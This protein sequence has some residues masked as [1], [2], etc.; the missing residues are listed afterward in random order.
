MKNNNEKD[1]NLNEVLSQKFVVSL[2]SLIKLFNSGNEATK[3]KEFNCKTIARVISDEKIKKELFYSF[4]KG[5]YEHSESKLR[6]LIK[7]YIDYIN[8]LYV[9]LRINKF[10]LDFL[11][12]FIQNYFDVIAL[13][14]VKNDNFF[15]TI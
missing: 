4:Y 6:C 7:K 5:V 3:N 10:D 8:S 2:D 14:F 15:A 12:N 13:F 1:F 9:D 11:K